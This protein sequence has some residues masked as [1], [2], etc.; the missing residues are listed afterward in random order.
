[1]IVKMW[2]YLLQ[3]TVS[4][5]YYVLYPRYRALFYRLI[6]I[7]TFRYTQAVALIHMCMCVCVCELKNEINW[8]VVYKSKSARCQSDYHH[9][10]VPLAQISLTLS[11]NPS[12]LSIAPGRSSRLHPVSAQ[13]RCISVL[14]GRSAFALPCEG[15]HRSISLT[16]SFLLLQQCPACLVRLT[17]IVF[18]MG[19]RRPYS[20]CFVGMLPPG[21]VLLNTNY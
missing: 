7:K 11:H 20:C 5:L 17:L 19:G 18:V 14:A 9:H 8:P 21:L 1:M 2:N 6:D 13:S 12:L 3:Y 10:A 16:S 4:E 15:V